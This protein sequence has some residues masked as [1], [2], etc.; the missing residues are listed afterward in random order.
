MLVTRQGSSTE[1]KI[2]NYTPHT[3][4]FRRY[5]PSA[6]YIHREFEPKGNAVVLLDEEK[7][8]ENILGIPVMETY[9]TGTVVGLPE[10]ET[11]TY[12]IVTLPTYIAANG[13]FDLLV[14]YNLEMDSKNDRMIFSSFCRPKLETIVWNGQ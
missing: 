11:D 8:L 4:V 1:K 2:H 7:P 14:M 13:R 6:G 10:P 12:L 3:A 9:S 5:E